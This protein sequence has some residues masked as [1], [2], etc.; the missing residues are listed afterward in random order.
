MQV[1]LLGGEDNPAAAVVAYVRLVQVNDE[2]GRHATVATQVIDPLAEG[3]LR[4]RA[5]LRAGCVSACPLQAISTVAAASVG[6]CADPDP[7][8]TRLLAA[9][10]T[11]QETRVWE[12]VRA[13]W[14]AQP[15][16]SWVNVHCDCRH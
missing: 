7:L 14:S 13:P 3:S 16:G 9:S 15:Y 5:R 10:A 8:V 2:N 6:R 4:G 1:Q 11:R 12:R